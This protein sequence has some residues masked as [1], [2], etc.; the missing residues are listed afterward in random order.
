MNA[1]GQDLSEWESIFLWSRDDLVPSRSHGI[2]AKRGH[3]V[4]RPTSSMPRFYLAQCSN[5]FKPNG[6]PQQ[7]KQTLITSASV[8]PTGITS[9]TS[10]S[11]QISRK[12]INSV[13]LG[14]ST[15]PIIREDPPQAIFPDHFDGGGLSYSSSSSHNNSNSNCSNLPPHYYHK[16]H[17]FSASSMSWHG[18]S[19]N[20]SFN[21]TYFPAALST[22]RVIPPP[23][24]PPGTPAAP[25]H[26]APSTN[27]CTP[28]HS[29]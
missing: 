2:R 17:T 12:L 14:G 26:N 25:A 4:S 15:F 1:K 27:S 21:S 22:S 13:A 28:P 3:C 24:A 16:V 10:T 7:Q 9:P 29:R 11:S 5:H 19:V 18:N 20:P 23:P 8:L 6:K